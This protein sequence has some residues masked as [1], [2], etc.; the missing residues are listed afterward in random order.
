[1]SMN[2]TAEL[3]TC[4]VCKRTLPLDRF[5]ASGTG[6]GRRHTCSRCLNEQLGRERRASGAKIRHNRY[7]ARGHVYCNHCEKYLPPETFKRHPSRP[8]TFWSYCK[9]CV[10]IKDRERYQKATSTIEGATR[11]LDSRLARKRRQRAA[12]QRERREYVVYAIHQL[13]LRGF[14]RAEVARLTGGADWN[15]D[16]AR[17]ILDALAA[18]GG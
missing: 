16:S 10:R 8:H 4:Q 14:T 3:R 11:V 9:P 17:A 13:R 15:S 1:M 6:S 18:P 2:V 12:E 7:N 5:Y